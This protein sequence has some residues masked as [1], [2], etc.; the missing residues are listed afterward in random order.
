[1]KYISSGK[2]DWTMEELKSKYE[3]INTDYPSGFGIFA[4]QLT[5]QPIVI[6]EAGLFNSFDN[7]AMLELGYILD[8]HHWHKGYGKEICNGLIRYCKEQL[9]TEKVI[10]RMY[11]ENIASVKLSEATGMTR[12]E[13]GTTPQGKEFYTYEINTGKRTI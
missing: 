7:P 5:D 12:T 1:M 2:Y 10:A 6:G 4:V 8:Q 3:K 9:Q 11:A 13:T